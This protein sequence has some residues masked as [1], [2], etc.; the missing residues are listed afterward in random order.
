[1]SL[2]LLLLILN[3]LYIV[4][5]SARESTFEILNYTQNNATVKFNIPVSTLDLLCRIIIIL[6]YIRLYW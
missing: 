1:M 3:L 2:L 4:P 5:R 6:G